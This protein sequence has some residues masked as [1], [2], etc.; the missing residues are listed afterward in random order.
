MPA[1]NQACPTWT[2]EA[3]S[4]KGGSHSLCHSPPSPPGTLVLAARP[5]S[6]RSRKRAPSKATLER[7]QEQKC[8]R[9]DGTGETLAIWD[10]GRSAGWGIQGVGPQAVPQIHSAAL[11]KS[12]PAWGL[13]FPVL[14]AW[15]LRLLSLCGSDESGTMRGEKVGG[16]GAGNIGETALSWWLGPPTA[17]LL[18]LVR[19]VAWVR[20]LKVPPEDSD[21]HPRVQ[22]SAPNPPQF[23]HLNPHPHCNVLHIGKGW[24]PISDWTYSPWSRQLHCHILGPTTARE[25]RGRV[26]VQPQPCR[27]L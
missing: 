12:V 2:L 15:P 18:L 11:S 26:E 27:K 24:A 6:R 5:K 13:S 4:D 9:A 25:V 23:G 20:L 21:V 8:D 22:S 1:G 19:G 10:R 14:E 7:G 17:I 3:I 16:G